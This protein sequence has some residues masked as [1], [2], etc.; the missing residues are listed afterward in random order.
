MKKSL[1]KCQKYNSD[2]YKVLKILFTAF[3]CYLHFRQLLWTQK[4]TQWL[5]IIRFS[6]TVGGRTFLELD[7]PPE[8]FF[9]IWIQSIL[10]VTIRWWRLAQL[11]QPETYTKN[12][13]NTKQ[14]CT[15]DASDG[16][17]L[18]GGKCS[19]L[20]K[21]TVS[22]DSL[23]SANMNY[24]KVTVCT[25]TRTKSNAFSLTGFVV[26]YSQTLILAMQF[27]VTHYSL[28]CWLNQQKTLLRHTF[29]L[30]Y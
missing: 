23:N 4:W 9:T 20:R 27:S 22:T 6:F 29:I 30:S 17:S 10:G 2:K 7:A 1:K 12:S 19:S 18:S 13:I 16:T 28:F 3:K 11:V 5:S 14:W 25:Y 24:S 15:Q 26:Y 21:E 8:D